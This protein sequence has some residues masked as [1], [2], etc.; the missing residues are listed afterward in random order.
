MKPHRKLLTWKVPF[1]FGAYNKRGK[2]HNASNE[3][4]KDGLSVYFTSKFK[5]SNQIQVGHIAS[6]FNQL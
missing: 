1:E 5:R 2:P 3:S 6:Y 4:C